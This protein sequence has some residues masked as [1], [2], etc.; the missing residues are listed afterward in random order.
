MPRT[1]QELIE[2]ARQVRMTPEELEEQR[3][4]FAFGNANYEDRRVTR[5]HVARSLISLRR[6]RES[7]ERLDW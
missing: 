3:V 2:M 7:C 1:L 4:S 5:D 6:A